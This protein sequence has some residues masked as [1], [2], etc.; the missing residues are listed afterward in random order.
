MSRVTNLGGQDPTSCP[1]HWVV[2]HEVKALAKQLRQTWQAK[3]LPLFDG[4]KSEQNVGANGGQGN[5]EDLWPV[6]GSPRWPFFHRNI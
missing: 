2:V 3:R 6:I 5:K 4:Y 1:D